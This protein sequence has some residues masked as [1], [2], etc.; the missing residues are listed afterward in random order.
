MVY[1]FFS[2][3]GLK[4]VFWVIHNIKFCN[5]FHRGEVFSALKL[6]YWNKAGVFL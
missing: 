1:H 6:L 3:E 2:H 5:I 4:L